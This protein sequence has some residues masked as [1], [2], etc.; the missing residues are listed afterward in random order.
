MVPARVLLSN[1]HV[2]KPAVTVLT[3]SISAIGH[4]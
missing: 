2:R 3:G 1:M 4:Y